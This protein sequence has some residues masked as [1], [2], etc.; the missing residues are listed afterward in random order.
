MLKKDI[1]K[2]ALHNAV[3]YGGKANWGCNWKAAF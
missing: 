1:E 2:Y 3:K